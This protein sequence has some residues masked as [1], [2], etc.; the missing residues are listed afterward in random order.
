MKRNDH[1]HHKN[2]LAMW[3]RSNKLSVHPKK[4]KFLIFIPNNKSLD[5]PFSLYLNNND[6]LFNDKKK[7]V[8][9]EQVT[10]NSEEPLVKMLGILFDEK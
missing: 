1:N 2:H 5:V 10:N 7:I 4:S 6:P 9:L 8:A 3:Y